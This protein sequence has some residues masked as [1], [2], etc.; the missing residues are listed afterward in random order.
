MK[1]TKTIFTHVFFWFLFFC[2]PL[3]QFWGVQQQSFQ[4]LLWHPAALLCLV[5]F[6][7]VYYGHLLL[8]LPRF[9]AAKKYSL[10]TTCFV[11]T[12]LAVLFLKPIDRM[13]FRGASRFPPGI[14]NESLSANRPLPP[15]PGQDFFFVDRTAMGLFLMLWVL[16]LAIWLYR[17]KFKVVFSSLSNLAQAADTYTATL[18]NAAT[19]GDDQPLVNVI[20]ENSLPP[21]NEL[22]VHVEYEQVKIPLGDID[23]IEAFDGYVKIYLSTAEKPVLTRMALRA[24][25]EKLPEEKFIRIHRSFIVSADKVAAWYAAKVKL[26][27]GQELPVGRRFK[28]GANQ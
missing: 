3:I 25:S 10:Y 15:D 17:T 1:Q 11:L 26:K 21:E 2:Y 14:V 19:K 9:F 28:D 5:V 6:P 20:K 16:G 22:T 13:F 23:Y 7:A 27:N 4:E 8:I 12:G 18:E 24:V